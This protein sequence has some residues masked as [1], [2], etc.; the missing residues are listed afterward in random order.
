MDGR[1]AAI[2]PPLVKLTGPSVVLFIHGKRFIQRDWC[3]SSLAI[4]ATP[5]LGGTQGTH[6]H[7]VDSSE[8]LVEGIARDLALMVTGQGRRDRGDLF[9][10][11]DSR[12]LTL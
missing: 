5:S 2:I 3:T 6:H 4:G 7:T 9:S 8:R 1:L 12:V 10:K 11:S